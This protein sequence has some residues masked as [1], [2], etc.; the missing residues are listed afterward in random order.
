[1][2]DYTSINIIK[3][4][5]Q[6][7]MTKENKKSKKISSKQDK[8]N[9]HFLKYI[10][11]TRNVSFTNNT[12]EEKINN[13]LN[14]NIPSDILDQDINNEKSIDNLDKNIPSDIL[15]QK[16]NE[17]KT[18]FFPSTKKTPF[19]HREK[20]YARYPSYFEEIKEEIK[21]DELINKQKHFNNLIN[22]MDGKNN[23]SSNLSL[24]E[25]IIESNKIIKSKFLVKDKMIQDILTE[26]IKKY[27]DSRLKNIIKSFK[28]K[29]Q[30]T[31]EEK[32]DNILLD[33]ETQLL[34]SY[35]KDII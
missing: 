16:L 15:N 24:H 11:N 22:N 14:K 18:S 6:G 7:W 3:N 13:D 34:E 28:L 33:L 12:K 19:E 23:L 9:N 21:K 31:Y 1:M 8:T 4:N 29:L 35:I 32:I 25:S 20:Y 10:R 30:K 26:K 5:E 2:A 27:H 17:E